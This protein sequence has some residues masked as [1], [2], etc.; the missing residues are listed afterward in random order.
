MSPHEYRELTPDHE[1]YPAAR[2]TWIREG[3][4]ASVIWGGV[5]WSAINRNGQ[6]VFINV[7]ALSQMDQAFASNSFGAREIAVPSAMQE[8]YELPEPKKARA[9]SKPA[10]APAPSDAQ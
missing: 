5:N 4:P 9:K 10:S 6:I 2:A 1:Y 8:E 3:E 7:G